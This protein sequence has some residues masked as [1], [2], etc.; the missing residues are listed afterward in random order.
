[1]ENTLATY[2]LI[3]AAVS[4]LAA[5]LTSIFVFLQVMQSNKHSRIS[6]MMNFQDRFSTEEMAD[7]IQNLY[8][9]REKYGDNFAE[10]FAEMYRERDEKVIAIN[11]ARRKL[12]N[13]YFSLSQ[14]LKVGALDEEMVRS[15]ITKAS[16][17]A[18]F[19]ICAPMADAY[20]GKDGWGNRIMEIHFL[21]S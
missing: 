5:L 8:A 2:A 10:R 9:F 7:A 17:E 21:K 19:N 11:L 16:T 18:F 12:G 1:M 6:V 20:Y 3:A 4:S 13:Y 15:V 14:A